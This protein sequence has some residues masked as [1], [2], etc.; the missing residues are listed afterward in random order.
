MHI[1]VVMDEEYYRG[2]E[3]GKDGLWLGDPET[4]R[5]GNTNAERE[6]GKPRDRNEDKDKFIEDFFDWIFGEDHSELVFSTATA[7][8]LLCLTITTF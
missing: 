1:D 6:I 4:Y 3:N 7:A 8:T 2:D 5:L